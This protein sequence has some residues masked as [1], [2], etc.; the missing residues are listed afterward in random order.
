MKWTLGIQ[1]KKSYY[2]NHYLSGL[3]SPFAPGYLALRQA[4]P[5]QDNLVKGGSN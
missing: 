4:Q 2:P 1:A 5:V 3:L